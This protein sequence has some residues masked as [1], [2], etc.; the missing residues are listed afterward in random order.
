MVLEL[1]VP[2]VLQ[3]RNVNLLSE[4]H[5]P[6]S[7]SIFLV[8]VYHIPQ[9]DGRAPHALQTKSGFEQHQNRLGMWIWYRACTVD[10]EI[11]LKC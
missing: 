5:D 11:Y 2:G 10:D 6:L 1:P 4:S 3:R 8:C 9:Q 7:T